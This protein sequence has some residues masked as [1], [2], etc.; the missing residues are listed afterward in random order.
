MVRFRSGDTHRNSLRSQKN[1]R[2]NRIVTEFLTLRFNPGY[3]GATPEV[4]KASISA[5]QLDKRHYHRA[6]LDGTI[7]RLMA[8]RQL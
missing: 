7:L 6:E 1:Q 8:D 2:L 5:A 3:P 4:E